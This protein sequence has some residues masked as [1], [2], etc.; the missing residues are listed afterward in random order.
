MIRINALSFAKLV[1]CLTDGPSRIQD[2]ADETG[3]HYVT[4]RRYLKALHREHVI[5]ISGWE[6][7]SRGRAN[8]VVYAMGDK[9]DAKRP[10]LSDAERQVRYRNKKRL[11]PL[12]Q[13]ASHER[14]VSV[15]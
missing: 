4:A 6:N 7:D 10:R 5:H 15:A 14:A 9:A 1:R 13:G 3:L 2:V 8:Q 12:M 11:K